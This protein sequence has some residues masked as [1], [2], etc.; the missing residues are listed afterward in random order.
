MWLLTSVVV[1]YAQPVQQTKDA[2]GT[3]DFTFQDTPLQDALNQ[4]INKTN[5]AV[6]FTAALVE[7]ATSN[8]VIKDALAKTALDCILEGTRIEAKQLVSGTYSLVAKTIEQD[9]A[10]VS[11][12]KFT[13][14][15]FI[16][17]K[18]SGEKLISAAIYELNRE[19]GVTTN[20]YGYYSL[21]LP[22]GPVSLVISYVGY[23]RT[24]SEFYLDKDIA[25]NVD[26]EP[27]S[28]GLDTLVVTGDRVEQIEETTQMSVTT[29]PVRQ[30]QSM[31]ALL[32]E[33]DI[34]RAIQLLPGVQSGNEGSTG[35][36]IRGGSPDQ[37]L[38]L[39]DGAPVYNAS[40]LF[41]F[42]SVFNADAIRNVKLIKGGF[43]ARFG[44][45]LSSVLELSMKEGNMRKFAGSG[46][47]GVLS[48]HGLFEGPI[49]KDK[50]SFMVAGR[51]S[52][53]DLATQPFVEDIPRYF[54][55]DFNGKINHIFSQKDRIY[56]SFYAGDDRFSQQETDTYTSNFTSD[57]FTEQ[58]V[59]ESDVGLSWGNTLSTLRWNHLFSNKLFGNLLF[60][61][62]D[63]GFF[64]RSE[65]I[66]TQKLRETTTT[67]TT[68]INY[69]SGVRDVGMRL[70]MEYQ[71]NPAHYIRFGAAA[72]RHRYRTGSLNYFERAEQSVS[73]DTVLVPNSIVD[74]SEFS[75]Y[76][77]DDA[78]L[79]ERLSFNVGLHLSAFDVNNEFYTSIEPRVSAR[80]MLKA[81]WALKL[82]YAGMTQYVHL[83]TNSGLGLPT[84]LWVPSTNNVAP[85]R[86]RQAAL[87]IAHTFKGDYEFSIETYAKSMRNIIE[88]SEGASYFGIGKNWQENVTSGKGWSYGGEFLLQKKS[89]KTSGWIGYTLAWSN[90]KFSDLNFGRRFPYKFDRRH[91]IAVTVAHTLTKKLELSG[92]WVFGSGNAITLPTAQYTASAPQYADLSEGLFVI[93]SGD[94]QDVIES[95]NGFRM[96]S[97]HRLDLGMNYSWQKRRARQ[98]LSVGVYNVYNR[99]NPFFYSLQE[100]Y[101]FDSTTDFQPP[102]T[103]L[104]VTQTSLFPILP[105][106][107][108]SLT[109]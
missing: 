24:I 70:D 28:L 49:V 108:Y 42:L 84:D 81:D 1:A 22:E 58:V 19:V 6:I 54:F 106:V 105:S 57:G 13:I 91:D 64:T 3:Y 38:I 46:S 12:T 11:D 69:D 67:E 71:P 97:Y 74:A 63:Y 82:S 33:V 103:S 41:G 55:Y 50:T 17:D 102:Q 88:Y 73:L 68:R 86:S 76:G 20:T 62:S 83:L 56:L 96:R 37:N 95:R 90:R 104:K 18:L 78:R 60:L 85:Q 44:G 109:Y 39:V 101:D 51:R 2:P 27:S 98:K 80:Y 32:G 66:E 94:I 79:S 14:S 107:S 48:A 23:N 99:R 35:L 26:L 59:S 9:A 52:F 10:S 45:R 89:G 72:T 40:H 47:I 31:P 5:V 75:I 25:L 30:I 4:F 7:E 87:G 29:I 15:G 61:Y 65:E 53:V 16:Q 92:T 21:T 34:L 36:Y 8:C 93:N 100:E 77:E 43:P